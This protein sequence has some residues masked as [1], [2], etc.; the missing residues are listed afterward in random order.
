M[1]YNTQHHISVC[2][3]LTYHY[4]SVTTPIL[5]NSGNSVSQKPLKD[6]S[7][8]GNALQRMGDP[9]ELAQAIVWLTSGR[10][11]YITATTLACNGGMLGA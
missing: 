10:A 11:S 8:V 9:D 3:L 6:A 4:R 5:V 2:H 7:T 1:V